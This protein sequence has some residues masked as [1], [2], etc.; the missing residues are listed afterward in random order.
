MV[1]LSRHPSAATTGSDIFMTKC[2]QCQ[3]RNEPDEPY[4]RQCGHRRETRCPVCSHP[5]PPAY[6][7]CGQCGQDL[8]RTSAA[9]PRALSP[10]EKLRTIKRYLPDGLSAKILAQKSKIE[11]ERKLVTVMFCDMA[12]FM[13][14]SEKIGPESAYAV[15]DQVYEIL[16]NKVHEL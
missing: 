8:N 15:M 3:T 1:G 12:G 2:P 11:G 7:F 13:P 4:C 9:A 14:I 6:K 5:T 10:E 16:L